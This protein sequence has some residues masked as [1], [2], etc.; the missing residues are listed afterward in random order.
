MYIQN[1]MT[2]LSEILPYYPIYPKH[3]SKKKIYP[4]SVKILILFGI[5]LV[6]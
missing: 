5:K 2:N 6:L 1:E 3:N 4:H